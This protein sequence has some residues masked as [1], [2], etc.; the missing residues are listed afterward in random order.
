VPSIC[1]APQ[2]A[3]RELLVAEGFKDIRYVP[4]A[5]ENQQQQLAR[6]EVDFTMHFS[7]AAVIALDAGNPIKIL[8]GVHVGCFEL[9]AREGIH[10]MVDLKGRTVG[11]HGFDSSD[12]VFLSMMAGY[13][14]LDPAK[15]ISW[16]VSPSIEPRELFAQGKI[17]AFLGFPPDPQDLRAREIGRVI[18]NS[19][20]DQPWWQ[21]FCCMAMASTNFVRKCPIATKRALR[22]L[23]KATDLCASNPK[24]IAQSMVDGGFTDRFDYA[25]QTLNEVRYGVWRDYDP[26]DTVRFYALRLQE[27]GMIKSVPQEIIAAGTDWRFINELK[28]EMKV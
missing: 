5:A 23:L 28:R 22:A 8:A 14:G 4:A 9:F 2:Y 12:H 20:V 1:L 24:Q 18:V 7:A 27:L 13:V 10:G 6:G 21:Y 19:S 11:V 16:V 15:D 26:E 25:L 17:D 3:L